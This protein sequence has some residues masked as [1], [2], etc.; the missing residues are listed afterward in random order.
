MNIKLFKFCDGCEAYCA[1]HTYDSAVDCIDGYL[2]VDALPL[3]VF[4]SI[5]EIHPEE[6]KKIIVHEELELSIADI[7]RLAIKAKEQFPQ[8]FEI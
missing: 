2:D 4:E 6:W 3:E 8:I 7:I 5:E 1:A